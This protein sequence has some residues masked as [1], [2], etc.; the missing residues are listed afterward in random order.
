M[1]ILFP[2]LLLNEIIWVFE[3]L[4]ICLIVAL[5]GYGTV[6]CLTLILKSDKIS[7]EHSSKWPNW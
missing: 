2:M 5:L 3:L 4:W 7:F 6:D 1:E